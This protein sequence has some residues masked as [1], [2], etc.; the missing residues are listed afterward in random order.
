M[1]KPRNH[2][3]RSHLVPGCLAVAV[4]AGVR[5]TASPGATL[6]SQE[7]LVLECAVWSAPSASSAVWHRVLLDPAGRRLRSIDGTRTGGLLVRERTAE[8]LSVGDTLLVADTRFKLD[9]VSAERDSV[10]YRLEASK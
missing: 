9:I 6:W 4:D 2:A 5:V 8:L 10:V 3:L 7:D 1:P